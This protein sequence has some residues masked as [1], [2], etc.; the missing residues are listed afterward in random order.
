VRGEFGVDAAALRSDGRILIAESRYQPLLERSH[1]QLILLNENGIREARLPVTISAHVH[2][3][4]W[5]ADGRILVRADSDGSVGGGFEVNGVRRYGPARLHVDGS[6]DESFRPPE[7]LSSIRRIEPMRDGRVLVEAGDVWGYLKRLNADGSLDTNFH[8]VAPIDGF[9]VDPQNRIVALAPNGDASKLF[10]MN[11]DGSLDSTFLCSTQRFGL[12]GNHDTR[13]LAL[14]PGGSI[15]APAIFNNDAGEV[16]GGVTRF[17]EDGSVEHSFPLPMDHGDAPFLFAEENG[18]VIV[19]HERGLWWLDKD[20]RMLTSVPFRS[21]D[22]EHYEV[23]F[24]G[25]REGKAVLLHRTWKGIVCFYDWLV[26]TPLQAVPATALAIDPTDVADWEDLTPVTPLST[27]VIEGRS[28]RIRIHRLGDLRGPAQVIVSTRD[29]T[30]RA[31]SDYAPAHT[32]LDFAPY[33]QENLLEIAVFDDGVREFEQM[34]ELVLSNATGAAA[35]A[36]PMPI[37]I[38]DYT[39]GFRLDGIHRLADGRV[40][41]T[42]NWQSWMEHSYHE[43]QASWDLRTW[44]RVEPTY[45][46]DDYLVRVIDAQAAG[47]VGGKVFRQQRQS[48]RRPGRRWH[49]ELAGVGRRNRSRRSTV[50]S[51]VFPRGQPRFRSRATGMVERGKSRVCRPALPNVDHE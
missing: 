41:M 19:G 51:A 44:T 40:E 30:V 45:L 31:G 39:P 1:S 2:R 38:I 37:R 43:L 47:L 15:L 17:R 27:E 34:F 21:R 14:G 23:H 18:N 22:S 25:V 36:P 12:L 35:V 10:R 20:G 32:T 3:L 28:K 16:V 13:V 6:P 49:D 46:P 8:P 42:C 24:L 4:A 5:L 48:Q 50:R 26:R 33:D 9:V 7:G 29:V 11:P